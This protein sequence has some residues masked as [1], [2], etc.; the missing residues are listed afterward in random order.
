MSV[1]AIETSSRVSSVAIA[2]EN[3][4]LAEITSES[5]LTHSKTLIPHIE[6]VLRLANKK[7]NDIDSVA[8]SLGPGSFTGLRIGIAA[9]KAISYALSVKIYGVPTLKSL[10][11]HFPVE[12]VRLVSLMD[13]QKNMVYMESYMFSEGRLKVLNPLSIKSISDTQEKI[14]ENDDNTILLGEKAETIFDGLN[15]KNIL[16]APFCQRMPRA[17]LIAG[18]IFNENI[19]SDNLMSLEPLYIRRSEAE[20][21]WEKRHG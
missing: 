1:L 17:A 6:E 12:N 19:K 16:L 13:A 18:Y 9:A 11:Y 14:L 10:A 5:R 2:D 21:L 7:R 3:K 15:S 8:V 4:L 20:E